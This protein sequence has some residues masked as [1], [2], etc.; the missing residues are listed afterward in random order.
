MAFDLLR[1]DQTIVSVKGNE[2]TVKRGIAGCGEAQAVF[3]IEVARFNH[4][5]FTRGV[6]REDR[7]KHVKRTN[8]GR[9][10]NAP[11]RVRGED[12]ISERLL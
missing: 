10:L 12:V 2:V 6:A 7:A 1:D 8:I 9:D 3:G 5:P 4:F 11:V